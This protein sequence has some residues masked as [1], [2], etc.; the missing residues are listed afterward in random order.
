MKKITSVLLAVCVASA[1]FS[2]FAQHSDEVS[3]K[4]QSTAVYTL[5][6]NDAVDMAVRNSPLLEINQYKKKANK[7]SI[8]NAQLQE[9]A[10]KDVPVKAATS[11]E[12]FCLKNGYYVKAAKVSYDLSVLEEKKIKNSVSYKTTQAYYNYILAQKTLTAAQNAYKLSVDNQA[13]VEVQKELGIISSLDYQ[14]A[15]LSLDVAKNAVAQNERNLEIARDNLRIQLGISEKN[16]E[17]NIFEDVA[18]EEFSA[19]IEKDIKSS[20]DTR[21]DMISLKKST[22]LAKEYFDLSNVLTSD[23][24]VYNNAYASYMETKHNYDSAKDNVALV[25]KSCSNDILTANE[26]LSAAR[27]TYELGLKKYDSDKLRYELGMITNLELTETINALYEAQV[28][29]ANAKIV[30]KLSVEKYRYE[31]TTGL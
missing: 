5:T 18:Y 15:L 23:S 7:K 22:E 31:I 28:Q 16:C 20:M 19:D 30:Y 27:N 13:V 25:I 2:V 29:Y 4:A 6:H 9:K 14:N 11:F 1:S 17:L 21:F 24:A 3:K 12:S 26:N 8:D 10:Y